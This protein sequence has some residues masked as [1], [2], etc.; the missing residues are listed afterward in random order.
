MK[1]KPIVVALVL[2]VMGILLALFLTR[3]RPVLFAFREPG[4]PLGEPHWSILH[5]FRD[6]TPE[7]VAGAILL[8]LKRG[9]YREA[10][11]RIHKSDAIK[12]EIES[13]EV[14]HRL[15]S[16]KLIDRQDSLGEVRLSYLTARGES[17]RLDSPLWI[18]IVQSEYQDGWRVADF[19][20]W[21]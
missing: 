4:D 7:R 19:E 10:L 5:P 12:S 9:E 14:K 8:D 3:S 18:T 15:K 16:W 1:A 6:R 11:S 2:L 17:S 21:Y 20:S 13:K